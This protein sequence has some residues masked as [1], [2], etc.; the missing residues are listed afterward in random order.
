MLCLGKLVMGQPLV[1]NRREIPST[2]FSMFKVWT[3]SALTWNLCRK[4]KLDCIG[5]GRGV[6]LRL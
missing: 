4:E 1:Y 5:D 3:I 6:S 2:E